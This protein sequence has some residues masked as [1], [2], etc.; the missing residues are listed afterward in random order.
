MPWYMYEPDKPAVPEAPSDSRA[1][2]ALF[3]F[4]AGM[5]AFIVML[6][7]VLFRAWPIFWAALATMAICAL[8]GPIALPKVKSKP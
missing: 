7:S 3:C 6:G 5:A 1:G 2:F 8:V 4:L